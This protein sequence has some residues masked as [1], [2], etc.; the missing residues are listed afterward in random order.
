MRRCFVSSREPDEH[1]LGVYTP[2]MSTQDAPA[3]SAEDVVREQGVDPSHGLS[4]DE[5]KSRLGKFGPNALEEKKESALLKFLSYFW[6]PLQ[7]T[8]SS[9][10]TNCSSHR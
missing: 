1:K 8:W 5:A 6:G 9:W 10:R 3:K 2:L 4:A 7:W